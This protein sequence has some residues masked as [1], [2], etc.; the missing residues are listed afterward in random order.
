MNRF[1]RGYPRASSSEVNAAAALIVLTSRRHSSI[2]R[3]PTLTVP[4]PPNPSWRRL[5]AV[6]FCHTAQVNRFVPGSFAKRY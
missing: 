4:F 3:S 2:E 5:Y 1:P 6:V